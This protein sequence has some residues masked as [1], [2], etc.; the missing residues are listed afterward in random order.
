MVFLLSVSAAMARP[1][2]LDPTFGNGGRV[3]T[4]TADILAPRRLYR[5]SDGRIVV[6]AMTVSQSPVPFADTMLL[7]YLPDGTLDPA[8]GND[9]MVRSDFQASDTPGAILQQPDT[10]IFVDPGLTATVDRLGN[11]VMRPRAAS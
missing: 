10:T 6:S 1:G 7:R 9:G 5:Q 4:G 2:D 8:F 11:L 3:V